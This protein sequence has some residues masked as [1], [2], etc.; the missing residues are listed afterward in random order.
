MGGTTPRGSGGNRQWTTTSP[1]MPE[2]RGVESNNQRRG[3]RAACSGLHIE[4]SASRNNVGNDVSIV[5]D[6]SLFLAIV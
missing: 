2:Q 5:N 3:A 4:S 6:E 1:F